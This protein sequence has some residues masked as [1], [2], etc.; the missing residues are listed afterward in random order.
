LVNPQAY[1]FALTVTSPARDSGTDL[2][3]VFGIDNHEAVDPGLSTLI[4]PLLR[5]SPWSRGAYEY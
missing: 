3:P 1:N 2:T 5:I 4:A